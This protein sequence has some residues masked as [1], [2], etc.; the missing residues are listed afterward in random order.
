MTQTITFKPGT[1]LNIAQV[2]DHRII[3][4]LIAGG[5]LGGFW[6]C[7]QRRITRRFT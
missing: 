6:N 2:R 1:D 7:G 5:T 3:P 4:H